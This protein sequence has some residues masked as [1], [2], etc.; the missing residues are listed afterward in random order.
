MLGNPNALL[1]GKLQ[2]AKMCSEAE[3]ANCYLSHL[4]SLLAVPK[5]AQILLIIVLP[6]L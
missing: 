4:N 2:L 3:L 5:L 1:R 6:I